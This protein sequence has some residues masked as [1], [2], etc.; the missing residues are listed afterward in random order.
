MKKRAIPAA[1][2]VLASVLF[3][4]TVYFG[5]TML[6][7]G[8]PDAPAIAPASLQQGQIETLIERRPPGPSPTPA[9]A[10]LLPPTPTAP[11]RASQPLAPVEFEEFVGSLC[12]NVGVWITDLYPHT[13]VSVDAMGNPLAGPEEERLFLEWG[14]DEYKGPHTQPRF[15]GYELTYR[16]ERLSAEKGSDWEWVADVAG[17]QSWEGQ[18]EPGEW[19]YRVA[20]STVTHQ[21]RTLPCFGGWPSEEMYVSIVQPP[22][23]AE[24]A[25]S[26]RNLCSNL[27]VVGLGGQGEWDT[28]SPALG[29]QRPCDRPIRVSSRRARS[30][31]QDPVAEGGNSEVAFRRA[32]GRPL[33]VGRLL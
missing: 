9:P 25:E 32:G 31:F 30:D 29:H 6:A 24:L 10:R 21:G 23:A 33:V 4:M 11:P 7:A 26:S 8:K 5:G 16:I 18:A 17:A 19:S 2:L 20:L 28:V 3:A 12:N 14:I 27:E 1:A 15:R 22:T 13:V